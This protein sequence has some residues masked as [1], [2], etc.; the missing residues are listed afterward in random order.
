MVKCVKGTYDIKCTMIVF[1][2][3]V[4]SPQFFSFDNGAYPIFIK[5][6]VIF[7]SEGI[8]GM[9]LQYCRSARFIYLR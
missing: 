2:C 1:F 6:R 8:N 3:Q 7:I 4:F 5:E 9:D